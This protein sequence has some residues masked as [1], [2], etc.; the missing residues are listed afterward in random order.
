MCAASLHSR[1]Q[2]VPPPVLAV[3]SE[4]C[5]RTL[6]KQPFEGEGC[7]LAPVQVRSALVTLGSL[8]TTRSLVGGRAFSLPVLSKRLVAGVVST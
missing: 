8:V 1:L 3:V 5:A 2:L 6:R 7:T 4:S